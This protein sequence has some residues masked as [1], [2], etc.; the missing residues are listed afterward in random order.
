MNKKKQKLGILFITIGLTIGITLL[1][2]DGWVGQLVAVVLGI[3]LLAANHNQLDDELEDL[4]K[5]LK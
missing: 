5:R 4:L 2:L 1:L 3:V